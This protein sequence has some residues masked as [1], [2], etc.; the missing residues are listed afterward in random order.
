MTE[1]KLYE[2][3]DKQ[4]RLLELRR[5]T[6]DPMWDMHEPEMAKAISLQ[7]WRKLRRKNPDYAAVIDQR[8]ADVESGRTKAMVSKDMVLEPEE[9]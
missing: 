2:A 1:E 9:E 3:L 8:I 7:M 6:Q 4:I 5:H